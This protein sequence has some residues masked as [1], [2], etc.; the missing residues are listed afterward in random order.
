MTID[1][2]D[3][4]YGPSP[5]G[6]E[7]KKSGRKRSVVGNWSATEKRA[8]KQKTEEPTPEKPKEA[9]DSRPC[10]VLMIADPS[11]NS[12]RMSSTI[13]TLF[14]DCLLMCTFLVVSNSEI[15]LRLIQSSPY[16]ILFITKDV[17]CSSVFSSTLLHSCNANTP[18]V[19]YSKRQNGIERKNDIAFPLTVIPYPLYQENNLSV[20][21]E[22]YFPFTILDIAYII[23]RIAFLP[24]FLQFNQDISLL[25]GKLLIMQER[26]K[27][28]YGNPNCLSRFSHIK[29][30]DAAYSQPVAIPFKKEDASSAPFSPIEALSPLDTPLPGVSMNDFSVLFSEVDDA[31][32]GVFDDYYNHE[33]FFSDALF[34]S[35]Q[36]YSQMGGYSD[37]LLNTSPIEGLSPRLPSI[38]QHI[39]QLMRNDEVDISLLSLDLNDPS[40]S[41]S[42]HSTSQ[43]QRRRVLVETCPDDSVVFVRNGKVVHPSCGTQRLDT[44]VGCGPP[45]LKPRMAVHEDTAEEVSFYQKNALVGKG[46]DF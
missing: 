11:I 8:K 9:L 13:T 24:R 25:E 10:L 27:R 41:P 5:S 37:P 19:L 29:S 22:L 7:R 35:L 12:K 21:C 45:H 2:E 42:T 38:K 18:I 23:I 33:G 16:D 36:T 46:G 40:P 20:T 31:M 14:S 34:P 1:D 3:Y 44:L 4:S 39:P 30:L 32:P 26:L 15:L 43:V 17:L 28:T 6:R